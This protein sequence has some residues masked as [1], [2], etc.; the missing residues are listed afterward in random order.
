MIKDTGGTIGPRIPGG[1]RGEY[2]ESESL[3]RQPFI[4]RCGSLLGYAVYQF[5]D[6]TQLSV[7][8]AQ[9]T[10]QFLFRLITTFN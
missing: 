2:S 9:A 4:L 1:T 10:K 8:V 5:F 7:S 3:R 6:V